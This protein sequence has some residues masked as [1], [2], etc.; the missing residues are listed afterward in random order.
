[1]VQNTVKR[2]S[3]PTRARTSFG[4]QDKPIIMPDDPAMEPMCLPHDPCTCFASADVAAAA[5]EAGLTEVSPNDR[6]AFCLAD[7]E[8]M[9]ICFDKQDL[10]TTYVNLQRRYDMVPSGEDRCK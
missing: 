10:P 9:D 5:L 8:G 6:N 1:M 2:S 7:D 3:T 4:V